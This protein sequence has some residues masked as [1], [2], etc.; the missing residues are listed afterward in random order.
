[1]PALDPVSKS[2]VVETGSLPPG[3]FRL[4]YIFGLAYSVSVDYL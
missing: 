4:P 3:T 1:M 2:E